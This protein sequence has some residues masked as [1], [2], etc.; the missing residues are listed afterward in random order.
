[1][2]RT[3]SVDSSYGL[4]LLLDRLHFAPKGLQTISLT[5]EKNHQDGLAKEP[6]PEDHSHRRLQ[7]G[8]FAAEN[9]RLRMLRP[10]PA[11]RPVDQ[12]HIEKSKDSVNGADQGAPIG[13]LDECAQ[14][15]IG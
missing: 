5:N 10:P 13:I 4:R 9:H 15:Q 1:M 7:P 2:P 14:Q 8:A 11:N 6:E 3:H 12:R